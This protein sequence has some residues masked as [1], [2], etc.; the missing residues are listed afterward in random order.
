MTYFAFLGL[1]LVVPISAALIYF[2]ARRKGSGLP[3]RLTALRPIAAIA[4]TALV[5]VI[6]TTPWD[7]YLVASGVW[8]YPRSQVS[9]VILGYV[10]LEEYLFFVLQTVLT[11]LGLI[12]VAGRSRRAE[13][14]P[15]ARLRLW[16]ALPLLML[17]VIACAALAGPWGPW[18]YSVLLLAWALPPI[19]IQV[20]FGADL[21]WQERRIALSTIVAATLYYSLADIFAVSAGTW[22]FNPALIFGVRLGPLPVEEILFFLLTNVLIVFSVTL[23]LSTA[24]MERFRSGV[25][26]VRGAVA[27]A[28]AAK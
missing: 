28:R 5:A 1:F 10:P 6:Y 11:S 7:N 26:R 4:I 24:S 22:D 3:P 16:A 12:W 19:L 21:L 27:G 23:L 17:W 8:G 15:P 20:I 9:G 18:R 25:A 14:G 2:A 13:S